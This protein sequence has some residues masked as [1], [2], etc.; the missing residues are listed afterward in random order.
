[1]HH[2]FHRLRGMCR[3]RNLP[4][5]LPQSLCLHDRRE[6]TYH[7]LPH[8]GRPE[9]YFL[10]NPPV[11]RPKV[12]KVFLTLLLPKLLARLFP[13]PHLISVRTLLLVLLL[14]FYR[15]GIT[16]YWAVT[17]STQATNI[18][19][20]NTF[21]ILF[22]LPNLNRFLKKTIKKVFCNRSFYPFRHSFI[23]SRGV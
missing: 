19:A 13:M 18:H 17:G 6:C 10:S 3:D 1:M 22:I 15:S 8:R 20:D 4:G 9:Y 11:W 23:Y 2:R 12:C 5:K 21:L 7:H 14:F 16:G